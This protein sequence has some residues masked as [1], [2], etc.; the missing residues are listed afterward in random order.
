MDSDERKLTVAATGDSMISKRSSVF[1]EEEFLSAINIIRNA[2]AAFTNCE[3]TFHNYES[4]PMKT[5]GFG[6]L[7][8][9]KPFLAEELKWVG[10]NL[11][12]LPNS[13]MVDD[14]GPYGMFSTMVTLDS[15]GI[16]YAGGGR[17]LDEAGAPK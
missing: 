13:H 14:F 17:D 8:S 16:T 1:R 5:R 9:A 15:L 7:L 6:T 3:T 12:A 2:D 10:F 11:V 4:F